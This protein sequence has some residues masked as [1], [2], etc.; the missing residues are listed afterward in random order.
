MAQPRPEGVHPGGPAPALLRAAL[1]Q[2]AHAILDPAS[3]ERDY[4]MFQVARVMQAGSQKY[5][6]SFACMSGGSMLALVG[7]TERLSEDADFN[8]SF[9][10][11]LAAC[12]KA[13]DLG[14]AS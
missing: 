13:I 14:M 10:G 6:G 2:H 8:V 12:S 7:I 9:P 5:P 1:R 3:I 11:G 4:W